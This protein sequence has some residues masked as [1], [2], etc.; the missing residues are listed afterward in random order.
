MR[1][2]SN[3]ILT[4]YVLLILPMNEV[5]ADLKISKMAGP[6]RIEITSCNHDAGAIC[7][8]KWRGKEF[9]DDWDRGRQL[10]TA[11]NFLQ[12]DV[13]SSKQA[14]KYNPTEAGSVIDGPYKGDIPF[15]GIYPSP[16]SLF[17]SSKMLAQQSSKSSS[18][19][20]DNNVL[21][22]VV[23]PAFWVPVEDP[24]GEV[25]YQSKRYKVLS[26]HIIRK[27]VT[28]GAYG[29]PHVIRYLTEYI[30]SAEERPHDHGVFEAI[31]GYMPK[32]F[33]KFYTFDMS[34]ERLRSIPSSINKE[35]ELPLIF[36]TPD[37]RWAMGVFSP[38][39][40]Q[41]PNLGYGAFKNSSTVKWNIVYRFNNPNKDRY[42]RL[43]KKTYGFESFIV[44]G[45][46]NNVKTSLIQLKN[47]GF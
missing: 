29:L 20:T 8:L 23:Q 4:A 38:L 16:N 30:V 11:A 18:G 17:S 1:S 10:Q 37:G 5:L 39:L 28:I 22:T 6:W 7:S 21:K 19:L 2:Y 36:S 40:P 26:N 14:E 12:T 46:L 24:N 47:L 41:I 44:V 31:T 32:E 27:E 15:K 9:I 13:N 34:S 25:T 3:L 45:S 33:S 35:Q 42:G 43:L